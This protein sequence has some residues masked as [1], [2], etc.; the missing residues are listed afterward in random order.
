M[1]PDDV[2]PIPGSEPESIPPIPPEIPRGYR[3]EESKK[4]YTTIA[5]ILGGVFFFL[6]FFIAF[7][8]MSFFFSPYP[9]GY[10]FTMYDFSR[11][12]IYGDHVYCPASTA[13][14]DAQKIQGAVM[15]FHVSEVLGPVRDRSPLARLF[16]S[17]PDIKNI[18]R[19]EEIDEGEVRLFPEVD[20]L[21]IVGKSHLWELREGQPALLHS[22]PALGDFSR[23]FSFDG[24][25]A[26]VE[27]RPTGQFL[28]VLQDGEWERIPL[29]FGL[30]A[31]SLN[32]GRQLQVLTIGD[33]HH[34]F[35]RYGSDIL[36]MV[37]LP[38]A[39]TEGD[40]SSSDWTPVTASE[41]AWQALLLDGQPAVVIVDED[42]L[43]GLELDGG[44]WT[45]SFNI[46]E[47]RFMSA[48]FFPVPMSD[49]T[50]RLIFSGFPG[51]FSVYSLDGNQAKLVRKHEG[52]FMFGS[53]FIRGIVIGQILSVPLPVALALILSSLM[54]RHRI[55]TYSH[56]DA[57]VRFASLGRRAISQIIDSSILFIGIIPFLWTL[58]SFI[59]SSDFG[60]VR[61][62]APV[63]SLSLTFGLAFLWG[64]FLLIAFSFLEGYM[65]VTPGKWVCRIR[66][67]GTDL[68]YCGFLRALIRNFLE[69]VDAFYYFMVGILLV[70][71]TE[72]WQ[73]L[74]D[75]AAKTIVI[76]K[77]QG[78]IRRDQAVSR[79]RFS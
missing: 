50:M 53:G 76:E 36:H 40:L 49:G 57:T 61:F 63:K 60:V 74:G 18:K 12:A 19:I 14:S 24:R 31:R 47:T 7:Y 71:F 73:R 65:G 10:E 26:V 67:L 22:Y 29:N 48:D 1:R 8:G 68:D 28:A 37:G 64:V 69:F 32:F 5:A 45:D 23:P 46:A 79:P 30:G 16:V 44:A 13:G 11:A 6:Q 66:V 33:T 77:P 62:F 17:D 27:D 72:N 41:G 56:G 21:L 34:V 9:Q 54:P 59:K 55:T 70:A 39:E 51:T 20:R 38:F 3:S 4:R 43:R 35:F 42:G 52:G 15:Q 75:M 58:S 78:P 2:P 25:L